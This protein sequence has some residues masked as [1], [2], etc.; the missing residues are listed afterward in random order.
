MDQWNLKSNGNTK[1]SE[2]FR[3]YQDEY[4]SLRVIPY[5]EETVKNT[6]NVLNQQ[7]QYYQIINSKVKIQLGGEVSTGNIKR[8]LLGPYGTIVGSQENNPNM[9]SIKYEVKLPYT[10]VKE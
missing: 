7:L 10:K 4:E 3:E 1:V 5:I 6:R 8:Q 9:N 2:N